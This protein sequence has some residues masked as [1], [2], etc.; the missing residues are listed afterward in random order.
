M[1]NL[2]TLAIMGMSAAMAFGAIS[3]DPSD[4][5]ALANPARDNRAYLDIR[6]YPQTC[7]VAIRELGYDV[8]TPALVEIYEKYGPEQTGDLIDWEDIVANKATTEEC[9]AILGECAATH[10]ASSI[11]SNTQ[12]DWILNYVIASLEKRAVAL[13]RTS[14]RREGKSFVTK[15]DVNPCAELI[16]GYNDA[17]NAP[18]F[19]GL[20]EWFRTMGISNATV[21]VSLIPN[22]ETLQT[23]KE[24]FVLGTV[25]LTE[26]WQAVL[27]FGLGT[28]EY[29]NFV[30]EYNG[31]D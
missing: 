27:R 18:R 20:G 28:E 30:K 17:M 22:A 16:K 9:I 15:G 29:N 2:I 5:D 12:G 19:A 4:A 24:K 6:R 1:K 3:P 23:M 10:R 26:N 13:V 25:E 11:A 21:N 7:P 14:L 8:K 31:E